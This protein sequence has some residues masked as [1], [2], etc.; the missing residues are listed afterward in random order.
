M[1]IADIRLKMQMPSVICVHANNDRL[2][3]GSSAIAEKP[4]D[5]LEILSIAA[6]LYEKSHLERLALESEILVEDC[7]F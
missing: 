7:R 5:A 3:T 1:M 4:R 2:M 6:Q